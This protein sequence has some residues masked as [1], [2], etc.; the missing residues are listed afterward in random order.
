MGPADSPES[1][2]KKGTMRGED[3]LALMSGWYLAGVQIRRH[4]ARQAAKAAAEEDKAAGTTLGA[5]PHVGRIAQGTVTE[6]EMSMSEKVKPVAKE[7]KGRVHAAI[8]SN[9]SAS[10]EEYFTVT[11]SSSYRDKEGNWKSSQ[12]IRGR[13]L[14][15]L[16]EVAAKCQLIIQEGLS[17]GNGT[18]QEK[19][20]EAD[21]ATRA[22]SRDKENLREVPGPEGLVTVDF[23]V[24]DFGS[25]WR[26]TPQT[27]RAKDF[28][29]DE[30]PLKPWQ[31]DTHESFA[32]DHR[33]ARQLAQQLAEEGWEVAHIEPE[34][35]LVKE[36]QGE[37]EKESLRQVPKSGVNPPKHRS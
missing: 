34:A 21:E 12:S 36:T 30:L 19:N 32:L 26:F 20:Q 8:W 29:R 27:E 18:A 35:M 37:A 10:G 7:G 25:V 13:D 11:F 4:R 5:A 3:L 22:A 24:E 15:D 23:L 17:Q 6:S 2:G 9:T 28:A 33:P 1:R 16:L 31:R 14:G